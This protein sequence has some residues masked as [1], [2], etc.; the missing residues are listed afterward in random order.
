[1]KNIHYYVAGHTA[2]GYVNFIQSN[3][4]GL[5]QINI[6][7]H[8]S[9]K[10]KTAFIKSA[11]SALE[12]E[13]VEIILHPRSK[14]YLAG[15]ICPKESLAILLED[16]EVKEGRKID[17][18]K[19]IIVDESHFEQYENKI[20][21]ILQRAYQV[22]QQGLR[23]HDDLEAVFINEM[24]FQRADKL[25]D[26]LIEELFHHV[27][28][29]DQ[30]S[31]I[32]KR[33]FG[34]NTPDGMTNQLASLIEDIDKRYFIKGR[35][36]TG[37]SHLM[38]RILTH[39]QAYGLDVEVYH[40]SFDPESIDMLI[41]RELNCCLFD[42]TDPH[43]LETSRSTDKVIDMYIQ[44]VKEGTDEKYAKEIAHITKQYKAKMK[45]GLHILQE[46]KL[47]DERKEAVIKR[48]EEQAASKLY[49]NIFKI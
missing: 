44:T 39:C 20:N 3:L 33:L 12:D 35:A 18:K 4:K 37:K 15:F 6:L 46:I 48:K 36:G 24:D 45:E 29:K 42:S 30:A 32:V 28:K 38:R 49:E 41:I 1:M 10:V 34:T 40:C 17:L 47:L 11:L 21:P 9:N 25:A 27:K 2:A 43:A 19:H 14:D 26:D 16:L 5:G 7:H 13:S 8:P 22:F 31:T 23:I